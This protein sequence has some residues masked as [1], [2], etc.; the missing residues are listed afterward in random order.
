MKELDESVVESL[1][2]LRAIVRCSFGSDFAEVIRGDRMP[3]RRVEI[4]IL[5]SVISKLNY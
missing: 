1:V 4:N 3:H 2:S 5:R